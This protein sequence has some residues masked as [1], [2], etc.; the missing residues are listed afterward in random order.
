MDDKI[1]DV[2]VNANTIWI[3]VAILVTL[4]VIKTLASDLW[5]HPWAQR[6][7]QVLPIG[8]GLVIAYFW[9]FS[10]CDAQGKCVE[11]VVKLA[12]KLIVGAWCGMMAMAAYSIVKKT[13]FNNKDFVDISK[14]FWANRQAGN[15]LP[16]P[17]PNPVTPTP[18]PTVTV[19]PVGTPNAGSPATPS[20]PDVVP[21][22]K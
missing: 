6:I 7:L 2:L 13:I 18:T 15:G 12:N 21:P 9:R 16:T 5:E 1:F 19:P 11:V 3:S 4:T 10:E 22:T 14:E 17:Q 20:G 8:L